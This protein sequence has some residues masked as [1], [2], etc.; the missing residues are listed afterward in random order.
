MHFM[1]EHLG[2]LFLMVTPMPIK[3][4]NVANGNPFSNQWAFTM[5]ETAF[6][7]YNSYNLFKRRFRLDVRKYVFVNS[8]YSLRAHCANFSAVSIIFWKHASM[9]PETDGICRS[10]GVCYRRDRQTDGPRTGTRRLHRLCKACYTASV[11]N[12]DSQL[13]REVILVVTD[14]LNDG[15]YHQCA[16]AGQRHSTVE[17][18]LH[19]DDL[20]LGTRRSE[21][22][23]VAVL[24]HVQPPTAWADTQAVTE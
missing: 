10:K 16:P 2:F 12:T 23:G 18:A 19:E 14:Y 7:K 1:L 17:R 20:V 24:A 22:L 11:N 5:L 6:C 8:I 13:Y 9:K 21:H 4:L 3:A 15:N